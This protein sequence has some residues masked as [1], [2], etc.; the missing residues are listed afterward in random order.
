MSRVV[1]SVVLFVSVLSILGVGLAGVAI[2]DESTN[3]TVEDD[4]DPETVEGQVGDVVLVSSDYDEDTQRLEVTVRNDGNFTETVHLIEALEDD[5]DSWAGWQTVDV[6]AGDE[7]TIVLDNV[8]DRG[9]DN[10]VAMTT[11]WGIEHQELEWI[12]TGE[13]FSFLDGPPRWSYYGIGLLVGAL[14]SFQGTRMWFRRKSE[15]I[16]ERQSERVS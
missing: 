13:G 9:G 5:A 8:A 15:D 16:D 7:A 10:A 1:F 2:A 12:E 11:D 14:G 4:D 3:E 6:R